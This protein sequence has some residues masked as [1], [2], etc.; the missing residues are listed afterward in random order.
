MQNLASA[1]A[2]FHKAVGPILKKS[3]AQYGLYAD[4]STVLSV[5]TPEL[6][7]KGLVLTQTFMPYETGTILRTSLLHTSGE[8]LTSDL[9][10]LSTDGRGNPLHAF[11]GAVTYLRRYALLAMLNL[12]AEDDD[13]DGWSE[14]PK[15]VAKT[16]TGTQPYKR[17]AAPAPDTRSTLGPDQI[18]A[19]L[20]RLQ[21]DLQADQLNALVSAYRKYKKLPASSQIGDQIKTTADVEFINSWIEQHTKQPVTS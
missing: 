13:G 19:L 6:S 17:S 10:M 11:G 3:T 14:P 18:K 16:G 9:P 7:A 20:A 2:E 5:V 1:L 8:T 15:A 21:A 4:L 12:A